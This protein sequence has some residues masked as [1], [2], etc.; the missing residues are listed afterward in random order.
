ME[1]YHFKLPET[2]D[3]VFV[4]ESFEIVTVDICN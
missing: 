2:I 3:I 4:E 1:I